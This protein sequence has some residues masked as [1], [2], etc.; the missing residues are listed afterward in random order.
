MNR[1]YR[2]ALIVGGYGALAGV[3]A[4][5][6]YILMEHVQHLL[7]QNPYAQ[8]P[9][10]TIAVIM[11]GGLLLSLLYRLNATAP[12]DLNAQ[13]QQAHDPLRQK[14]R[15][16]LLTALIAIV[17]VGFGGAVGPEAG[18]IAVVSECSAILALHL[19]RNQ[20]EQ[21]LIGDSGS[22]AALSGLYGAPPGAATLIDEDDNGKQAADSISLPL[23][24]LA[25]ISG[26]AG[27]YLTT[28][29]L[30]DG[31]FQQLTLPAHTIPRNGSDLLLAIPA[32]LVGG[33][34]GLLAQQLHHRI[35][36]WLARLGGRDI[37]ILVGSALF[38]L[39]CVITPA[40]RFSG[41]H[42]VEHALEHGIQ[43]GIPMLLWLGVGKILALS[44]CLGSLWKG[45]EIFPLIFAGAAAGALTH[46][47]PPAIPLTVALMGGIAATCSAGFGKPVS[48]LLILL[49]LVGL[50]SPGALCTGILVGYAFHHLGKQTAHKKKPGIS[51]AFL[52][53]V[54]LCGSAFSCQ[55][56]C[57]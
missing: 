10:Y 22:I 47:L 5:M 41:H 24:L 21:R 18:L 49:L 38:A 2:P 20:A 12:S 14:K 54:P 46:Q 11:G 16:T 55:R 8:G 35:P 9:L 39:L 53:A 56:K 6:T 36:H 4:A 33:L 31:G 26:M 37:Q 42:E 28:Q 40:L 15:A 29:L 17:S 27:F 34:L 48:V 7:W 57:Y 52:T 51:P 25:G 3:M 1:S 23:K 45:G 19:A 30:L 32:A 43:S 44:L 13:L 50:D